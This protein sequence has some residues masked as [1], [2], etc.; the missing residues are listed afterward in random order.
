MSCAPAG[1]MIFLKNAKD[2]GVLSCAGF[3]MKKIA[4]IPWI[5]PR[6][7]NSRWKSSSGF[8][9]D[10][11]TWPIY[12][13]D[14][15]SRLKPI[16]RDLEVLTPT[17]CTHWARNGSQGKSFDRCRAGAQEHQKNEP[18]SNKKRAHR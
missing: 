11:V 13:L 12:N 18:Q 6:R 16:C 15:D 17:R 8:P 4:W 2:D 10:T 5:L 1:F 9:R 3:F 14:W 7:C